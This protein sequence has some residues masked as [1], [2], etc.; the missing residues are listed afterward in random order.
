MHGLTN[1]KKKIYEYSN[2]S[3]LIDNITHNINLKKTLFNMLYPQA[4]KRKNVLV[5]ASR[6]EIHVNLHLIES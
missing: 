2:T 3:R 4:D 5:S 1:L 6:P